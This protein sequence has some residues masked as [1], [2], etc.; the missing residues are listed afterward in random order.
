MTHT[1]HLVP[2]INP[3]TGK[4][5]LFQ[6][7]V[8]FFLAIS[9]LFHPRD[10]IRVLIEKFFTSLFTRRTSHDVFVCEWKRMLDIVI[11]IEHKNAIVCRIDTHLN[12][13]TDD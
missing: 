2:K 3:K 10:Y 4:N 11:E 8:S 5:Q 1:S 13:Q 9:L 7:L 12:T 6:L